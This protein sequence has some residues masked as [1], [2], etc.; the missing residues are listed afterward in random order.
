[1]EPASV[2]VGVVAG[3]TALVGTAIKVITFLTGL[4]DTITGA[5]LL[6]LDLHTTCQAYQVAWT[7]T[8]DWASDPS[9]HLDGSDPILEQILAY[10]DVSKITLDAIEGD[11]EKLDQSDS[12]A[13]LNFPSLGRFVIQ[14]KTFKDHCERLNRHI[15]SLNLL[16][17][18]ARL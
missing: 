8:R 4:R 6:L 7:H 13:R 10:L 11:L 17:A 3:S 16:M 12:S 1:M 18:T 14:G 5:N 15:N 9:R 2:V